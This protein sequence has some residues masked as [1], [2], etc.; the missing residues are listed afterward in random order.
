[1][2]I[3]ILITCLFFTDFFKFPE[4]YLTTWKNQLHNDLLNGSEVGTDYFHTSMKG[5]NFITND[6]LV[7][8]RKRIL[9][10]YCCRPSYIINKL[11]ACKFNPK[12]VRNYF[13]YGIRLIKNIFK[14]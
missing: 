4:T 9:F 14:R 7:K 5:T 12:I 11:I 13:Y 3:V 1:M 8:I 10:K 6:K 2:V